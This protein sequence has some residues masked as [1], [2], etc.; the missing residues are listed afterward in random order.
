MKLK[1]LTSQEITLTAVM[2]ALSLILTF[3]E[4]PFNPVFGLKIDF[5]LVPI[6]LVAIIV[7]RY[8]GIAALLIQFLLVFFRNPAGWIFNAVAG[9]FFIIPFIIALEVFRTLKNE[10]P[11][12]TYAIAL[13]IATIT[14]TILTTLTNYTL[15]IPIL[16]PKFILSFN[17]TVA[18][19]VPFNFLK[20]SLISIMTLIII[21]Q[22][23]QY[24]NTK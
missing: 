8:A 19:Y 5:A 16:F 4:I 24:F 14:T 7:N 23:K 3:L 10:K 6:I 1:K 12:L 2:V 21:P 13:F 17:Q 9:I 22:V 11:L 20:F 18:A 15:L